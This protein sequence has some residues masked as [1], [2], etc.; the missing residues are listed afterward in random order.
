[1]EIK[2]F[3]NEE[4]QRLEDDIEL[5]LN[6]G[7]YGTFG[8]KNYIDSSKVIS[9]K[10]TNFDETLFS[11]LELTRSG[12]SDAKNA[13][14]IYE[15]LVGLSP[16]HARDNRLWS[17][18][19]HTAGLKFSLRGV[20]DTDDKAEQIKEIKKEFFIKGNDVRVYASRHSLSKLWWAAHLCSNHPDFSLDEALTIFCSAS[21]FRASVIERPNTYLEPKVFQAML[22]VAQKRWNDENENFSFF[23]RKGGESAYRDWHKLVNRNGGA[24][25]FSFMEKQE[26]VDMFESTANQ[27]EREFRERNGL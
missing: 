6:R 4:I 2:I 7:L 22:S 13:K 19:S 18:L 21:D 16:Y 20:Y 10:N 11:K 14:I 1:M 9:L 8:F 23:S 26:L 15:S 27:A 5:N 17:Y 3:K 12:A 24:K 25:L